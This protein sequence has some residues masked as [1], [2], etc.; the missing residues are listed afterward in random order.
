MIAETR[1]LAATLFA[2][3]DVKL[4][5]A[6]FPPLPMRTAFKIFVTEVSK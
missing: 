2:P 3:G 1:R 6:Q 4:D 5:D